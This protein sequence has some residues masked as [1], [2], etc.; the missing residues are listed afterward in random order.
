LKIAAIGDR[1]TV[2]ALKLMG[3]EGTAVSTAEEAEAAIDAVT[4]PATVILITGTAADMIRAKVDKMKVARQ[5]YIVL[6]IPST[7]KVP[8]QAEDTARLVSQA[9]GV[10]I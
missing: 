4:A 3:I 7:E 6:E 2:R 9:I 10:K 8:N 1:L 5:D